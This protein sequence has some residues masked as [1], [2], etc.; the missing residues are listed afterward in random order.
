MDYSSSRNASNRNRSSGF[1]LIE[2][3]VVIAIIGVLASMLLPAL[4]Q[5]KLRA[6]AAACL[7]NLQQIGSATRLYIQDNAD[8]MPYAKIEFMNANPLL[9]Q[10]MTWDDLLSSYLEVNLTAAEQWSPL[11]Q[12]AGKIFACPADK[13]DLFRP[14]TQA[15][16]NSL[17]PK[18]QYFRRTYSMPMYQENAAPT[19]PPGSDSQEGVGLNWSFPATPATTSTWNSADPTSGAVKPSNQAAIHE[20]YLNDPAGT[21]THTE[22]LHVDNIAGW[23][24]RAVI[25][26]AND[27][28]PGVAAFYA[29]NNPHHGTKAYSYLFMD[30]HVEILQNT[31]TTSNLLLRRGMWS[32]RAGD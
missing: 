19:W 27:H 4:Q 20:S 16:L 23:G 13:N 2:L 1:T 8:R 15:F 18:P 17:T 9:S 6:K 22:Y 32:I 25:A 28:Q 7:S 10:I 24:D 31:K 30:G 5:G 14:T 21:I 26:N 12:R 3:L 29:Y 11:N